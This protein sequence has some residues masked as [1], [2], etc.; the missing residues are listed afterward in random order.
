M[1]KEDIVKEIEN[2]MAEHEL[3]ERTSEDISHFAELFSDTPN[4]EEE[5]FMIDENY[6]ADLTG[7]AE[8]NC[9]ES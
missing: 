7:F 9:D 3:D 6:N 5:I 8:L 1:N 2:F 4:D